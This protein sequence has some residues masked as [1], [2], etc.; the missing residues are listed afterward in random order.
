MKVLFIVLIFSISAMARENE[1]SL[2]IKTDV[3]ISQ[4]IKNKEF[5]MIKQEK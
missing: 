2:K 1:I 5:K 4:K 3:G